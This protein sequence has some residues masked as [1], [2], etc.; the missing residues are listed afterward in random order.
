[1]PQHIISQKHGLTTKAFRITNTSRKV[2]DG[3]MIHRI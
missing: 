3:L 1:M 2:L